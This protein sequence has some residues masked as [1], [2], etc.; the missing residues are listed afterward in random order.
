[1]KKMKKGRGKLYLALAV[2]A[3]GMFVFGQAAKAA[4]PIV[5]Q[6]NISV[7]G[8]TGNGVVFISKN[9]QTGYSDVVRVEWDNSSDT[10]DNNSGVTGVTVD[11]S[12]FEGDPVVQAFNDGGAGDG[13]CDSNSADGIWTACYHISQGSLDGVG[14]KNVSVTATNA[15][16]PTTVEDDTNATVDNVPPADDSTVDAYGTDAA[17]FSFSGTTSLNRKVYYEIWAY[18]SDNDIYASDYAGKAANGSGDYMFSGINLSGAADGMLSM[19]VWVEDPAGNYS[20][21][22]DEGIQLTKTG[23]VIGLDKSDLTWTINYQ[24]TDESGRAIYKLT[25]SGYTPESWAAYVGEINGAIAVEADGSATPTEVADAIS[26][27]SVCKRC[28]D[29]VGSANTSIEHHGVFRR[30]RNLNG[31]WIYA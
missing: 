28:F 16:G 7:S 13:S 21:S 29:L 25:Q 24:Y 23:D 30:R 26:A 18:G 20:P 12:Q 22:W 1:M 2:A 3:V 5:T 9:E 17:N 4:A 8:A 11:F 15:D 6:E 10:G 31:Q 27:T 14:G 19:Y